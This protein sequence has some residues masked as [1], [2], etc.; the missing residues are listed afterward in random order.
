VGNRTRGRKKRIDE[1]DSKELNGKAQLNGTFTL[2]EEKTNTAGKRKSSIGGIL[3]TVQSTISSSIKKVT[4]SGGKEKESNDESVES[5]TVTRKKSTRGARSAPTLPAAIKPRP[6]ASNKSEAVKT[7][8]KLDHSVPSPSALDKRKEVVGGNKS[9]VS[10]AESVGSVQEETNSRPVRNR[11]RRFENLDLNDSKT[12][13]EKPRRG[14]RKDMDVEDNVLKKSSSNEIAAPTKTTLLTTRAKST[15]G[16]NKENAQAVASA[17]TTTVARSKG[18]KGILQSLTDEMYNTP[19]TK[20]LTPSHPKGKFTSVTDEEYF[21]PP[22][23][24]S[25]SRPRKVRK[26]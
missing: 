9:I 10:V 8:D 1:V 4:Q 5:L 19:D 2:E 12:P 17:T 20:M 23:S 14:R 25:K 15:R 7:S 21:T 3:G 26:K 13:K 11:K 6:T 16:G 18:K 24:A 22:T